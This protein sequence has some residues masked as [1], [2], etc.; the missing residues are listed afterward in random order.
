M[1]FSERVRTREHTCPQKGHSLSGAGKVQKWRV[2]LYNPSCRFEGEIQRS[3]KILRAALCFHK[4]HS[5]GTTKQYCEN[6]QV[7]PVALGHSYSWGP[8]SQSSRGG[9][10]GWGGK[11]GLNQHSQLFLNPVPMMPV[12][13]PKS[14]FCRQGLKMS[15]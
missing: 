6:D 1:H 3:I 15:T 5:L 9:G 8:R 14:T 2:S 11:T 12:D 10:G 13:I 4:A 7:T